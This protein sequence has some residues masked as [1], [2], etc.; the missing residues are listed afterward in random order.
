MKEA[1]DPGSEPRVRHIRPDLLIEHGEKSVGRNAIREISYDRKL[2][3]LRD[4]FTYRLKQRISKNELYPEEQNVRDYLRDAFHVPSFVADETPWGLVLRHILCDR[5]LSRTVIDL[6]APKQIKRATKVA[7]DNVK[8]QVLVNIATIPESYRGKIQQLLENWCRNQRVSSVVT[9]LFQFAGFIAPI[10]HQSQCYVYRQ[11]PEET[12]ASM[13]ERFLKAQRY[14]FI[15]PDYELLLTREHCYLISP[16]T[17]VY[18]MPHD[19]LLLWHNKCCDI[20]SI[21]LASQAMS[22]VSLSPSFA[23]LVESLIQSGVNIL[24]QYKHNAFVIFKALEAFCVGETL[25]SLEGP[26]NEGF[27]RTIAS[28]VYENTGFDYY[29]SDLRFCLQSAGIPERHELSCLSKIFGH[30]YVRM[31]EGAVKLC[32]KT[33]ECQLINVYHVNIV[34]CYVKENFIRN[35][36]LKH[37]VWP[38]V[39]MELMSED[40][41]LRRAREHNRQPNDPFI[42]HH[43]GEVKIEDYTRVTLLKC[44]EFD[45]LDNALPYLKD[46]TISVMRSK[47]WHTYLD[48]ISTRDTMTTW[49]E[50]RLLLAYLL[51]PGSSYDHLEYLRKYEGS[52]DLEDILD[53]L[54]PGFGCKSY[55]DRM[56]SICQESNVMSYLEQYSDEQAMTVTELELQEKLVAFRQLAKAY[57]IES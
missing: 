4:T 34:T 8:L 16:E 46:R 38:P 26:A 27:L 6:D 50:T 48:D 2:D 11:H 53:Y 15:L 21:L 1:I 20:I 9:R 37:G 51:N 36:I 23:Q 45:R 30:P 54:G 47:V 3:P 32:E 25:L 52:H 56:R 40:H 55:E 19:V 39:E 22:G 31:H 17:R 44:L 24:L 41:P 14:S 10:I 12:L 13:K 43:Y 35:Y 57:L 5:P 42:L 33:T 29:S 7:S 28:D 49:K 18:I